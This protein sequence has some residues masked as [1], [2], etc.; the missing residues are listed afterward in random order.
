MSQEIDFSKPLSDSDRAY[1]EERG[2]YSDI[3]RLDEAHGVSTTYGEGDGTGTVQRA[4]LTS[5]QAAT[6]RE[7]LLRELADLDTA[8]GVVEDEDDEDILPYNEWKLEELK[9]E[10]DRRNEGREG[11][12]R[13]AKTGN[14][15]VLADRL[16]KDDE[17]NASE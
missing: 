2:R 9:A 15:Q 8:E 6:R 14:V 16:Y 11:D 4:L 17:T 13:L 5:E 7:Q 12:A 3:E 1:L 10:I